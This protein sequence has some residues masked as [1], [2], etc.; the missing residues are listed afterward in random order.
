MGMRLLACALVFICAALALTSAVQALPPAQGIP[1]RDDAR[2]C[3]LQDA[4]I[5][6]LPVT[7][8]RDYGELY[9]PGSDEMELIE[10]LARGIHNWKTT[11]EHG[12]WECG[13]FYPTGPETEDRAILLAYRMVRAVQLHG[14]GRQG[15]GA[16]GLVALHVWGLA[17]TIAH[18]SSFDRCAVGYYFRKWAISKKMVKPRTR[19]ISYGEDEMLSALTDPRAFGWVHNTGV[20]VGYCQLLTRFHNGPVR[21]MMH[22][23]RGLEICAHHFYTRAKKLGTNRPWRYWRGHGAAQY[24]S[25][26]VQRARAMGALPGEI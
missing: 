22:P 2:V 6:P 26:V 1:N 17:G 8:F 12:W 14:V 24:E 25:R 5:E 21:E 15:E 9:F 18:E 10:R 11:R 19:T 13:Q 23:E 3:E 7:E 20:D 4:L 16:E